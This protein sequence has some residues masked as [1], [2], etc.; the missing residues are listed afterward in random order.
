MRQINEI[1]DRDTFVT[2]CEYL[3][4]DDEWYER[5]VDIFD[6]FTYNEVL[7]AL[8]NFDK[9]VAEMCDKKLTNYKQL[10]TELMSNWIG[11]VPVRVKAA[12]DALNSATE[13]TGCGKCKSDTPWIQHYSQ[14][15]VEHGFHEDI[16]ENTVLIRIKDVDQT[17]FPPVARADEFVSIY[18]FTF[19]DVE[20][21]KYG[22]VIS[23]EQA[24]EL[25]KILRLSYA[26]K[27]NAIVHCY[28]GLC[29]SSAVAVCG[30]LIGFKLEDKQRI[31]NTL[32]KTKVMKALGIAIDATTSVFS[33]E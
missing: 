5:S 3:G 31:P 16:G 10:A 2:V 20:D 25:A 19:D 33:E 24:M 15:D 30:E 1:D 28:A 6:D 9:E 21:E 14:Y 13:C 29:R 8:N 26:I 18:E 32:V 22:T 23:D 7:T 17:V 27:E 12:A 11:D 4:T